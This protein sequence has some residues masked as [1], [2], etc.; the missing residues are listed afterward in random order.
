MNLWEAPNR[1]N[2]DRSSSR[3]GKIAFLLLGRISRCDR[4]LR[5][6][7]KLDGSW[8]H[9]VSNRAIWLQR[10]ACRR[11]TSKRIKQHETYKAKC[12]TPR[13]IR[14][15]AAAGTHKTASRLRARFIEARGTNALSKGWAKFK[16]SLLRLVGKKKR[17][18]AQRS[19]PSN[20]ATIL[21]W[22]GPSRAVRNGLI[23]RE[24]HLGWTIR[25][26]K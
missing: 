8:H 21:P 22:A 11:P 16:G 12:A 24:R 4:A 26:T 23:S 9:Q 18:G 19:S 1:T 3:S 17:L 7:S 10:N 5:A 6:G 25:S 15:S 13:F 14:G 2:C 20:A